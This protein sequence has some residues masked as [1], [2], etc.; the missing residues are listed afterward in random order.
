MKGKRS[1]ARRQARRTKIKIIDLTAAPLTAASPVFVIPTPTQVHQLAPA[2]GNSHLDAAGLIVGKPFIGRSQPALL[3]ASPLTVASCVLASPV[4]AET[5]IS[6]H[7][8]NRRQWQADRVRKVLFRLYPPNAEV[9]DHVSTTVVQKQVANALAEE[10]RNL[11]IAA[12]SWDVVNR[13][14]GRATPR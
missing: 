5:S 9:P 14:L 12:P 10:S 4:L 3:T 13:V 11:G 1:A 6:K 7:P 8:G 2:S